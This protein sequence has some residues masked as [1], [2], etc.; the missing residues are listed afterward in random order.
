MIA[1]LSVVE[2]EVITLGMNPLRVE[3]PKP[4]RIL[5]AVWHARDV[6][7]RILVAEGFEKYL[8]ALNGYFM[9]HGF[10]R[11]DR[12]AILRTAPQLDCSYYDKS[13][14]T[15]LH[16]GFLLGARAGLWR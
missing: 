15:T 12:G 11:I 13:Q 8:D 3:F 16:T 2:A 14:N 4:D 6:Y 1:T 5:H 7:P 9:S 10:V